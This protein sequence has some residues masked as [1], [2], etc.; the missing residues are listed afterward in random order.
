MPRRKVSFVNGYYYH[1]FNRGVEKRDIFLSETDKVRFIRTVAYYRYLIKFPKFSKFNP[2]IHVN[3]QSEM[4]ISLIAFCLMPNHFHFLIRQEKEN[5]ILDFVRKISN[6][7]AKFFNIKYDR[8]GP[9]LQGKF[10][11][12]M[13]ESEE[14]LIHVA[15]Y[16][17]LNPYVI[18]LTD[19]LKNYPW[20]S[21]LEYLKKGDYSLCERDLLLSFFPNLE[22]Y[23]EFHNDQKDYAKS[24]EENK[25]N[26]IDN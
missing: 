2:N 18:G 7:Y 13:V 24:L 19:D 14:Q 16:I 1:V 8:V 25:H 3:V 22:S 4:L 12:V 15:R 17:H 26:F 5:G 11:A 6:S 21:Y 23:E 9:L 20:S 10:K